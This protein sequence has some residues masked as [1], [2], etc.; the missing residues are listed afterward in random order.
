M[1]KYTAYAFSWMVRILHIIF[2]LILHIPTFSG[3]GSSYRSLKVMEVFR[4]RFRSP[5]FSYSSTLEVHVHRLPG[6]E[7][8]HHHQYPINSQE[9]K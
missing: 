8:T 4:I 7:I 1:T 6:R 3:P 2:F 9:R 5:A